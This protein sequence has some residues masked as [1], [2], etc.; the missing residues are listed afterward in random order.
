MSRTFPARYSGECVR[1]LGYFDEG[2]DIAFDDHDDIICGE[3]HREA[4]EIAES[5]AV[6]A[7]WRRGK[8]R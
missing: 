4:E 2:D 5:K 8:K 6:K 1:C 7:D 3:C